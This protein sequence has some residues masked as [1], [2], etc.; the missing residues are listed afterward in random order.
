MST[1][2]RRSRVIVVSIAALA[3]VSLGGPA[4]GQ[5]ATY[6]LGFSEQTVF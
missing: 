3:A 4:A 2:L 1:L 5:A 6:P